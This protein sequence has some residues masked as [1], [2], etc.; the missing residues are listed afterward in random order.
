VV[1]PFLF[2]IDLDADDIFFGWEGMHSLLE[3]F[4]PPYIYSDWFPIL[5]E[6]IKAGRTFRIAAITATDRKLLSDTLATI[7]V[8]PILLAYCVHLI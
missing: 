3:E 2:E 7:K 6:L 5:D 1:V 8:V 4:L